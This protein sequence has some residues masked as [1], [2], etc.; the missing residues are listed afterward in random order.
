[1]KTLEIV[2]LSCDP[3]ITN[4]EREWWQ[5]VWKNVELV[6]RGYP[7]VPPEAWDAPA[8]VRGVPADDVFRELCGGTEA[9]NPGV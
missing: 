2:E 7:P 3:T 5:R 9:P 6:E 4:A 1:M 8:G